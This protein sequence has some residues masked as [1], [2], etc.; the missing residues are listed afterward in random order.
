MYVIILVYNGLSIKEDNKITYN[1]FFLAKK[2]Y[3]AQITVHEYFKPNW[4]SIEQRL[5][6]L[7][8]IRGNTRV[9]WLG[10]N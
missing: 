8:R 9:T 10:I 4:S 1:S 3:S 6:N 5:H 2:N 7:Y